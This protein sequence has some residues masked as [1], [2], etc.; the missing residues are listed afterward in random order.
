MLSFCAVFICEFC[1]GRLL[2]Y[3]MAAIKKVLNF[4][5]FPVT[6]G[7]IYFV[8]VLTS[9]NHNARNWYPEMVMT[10]TDEK[11]QDIDFQS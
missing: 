6:L 5:S 4:Y 10:R 8:L 1:F 7:Q 3:K 9:T 2:H 11:D